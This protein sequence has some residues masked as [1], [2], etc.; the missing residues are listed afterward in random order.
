MAE[1]GLTLTSMVKPGLNKIC[2]TNYGM[3]ERVPTDN[4]DIC[5]R[6]RSRCHIGLK[7]GISIASLN[8]DSLRYHF[9]EIQ[10]LLKTS[11]IHVI[12][13]NENKLKS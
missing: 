2:S 10:R 7:R 12:A 11:G 9:D 6:G 8:I 4:I 3:F 5:L 13:L 1:E